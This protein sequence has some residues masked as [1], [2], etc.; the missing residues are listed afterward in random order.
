MDWRRA[1][2][3]ISLSVFQIVDGLEEPF[4][5]IDELSSGQKAE[6]SSKQSLAICE[7]SSITPKPDSQADPLSN[8]TNG[9]ILSGPRNAGLNEQGGGWFP[10]LASL[11]VDV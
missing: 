10:Q 7:V 2:R 4:P 3:F 5:P 11:H 6:Q 8:T 1:C 9:T